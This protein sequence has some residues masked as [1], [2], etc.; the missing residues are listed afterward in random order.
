M[1]RSS[2]PAM[3]RR[4]RCAWRRRSVARW[5]GSRSTRATGSKTAEEIARIETVDLELALAAARAERDLAAAELRLQVGRLPPRGDRRGP[6]PGGARSGRSSRPPSAIWQRFQGLLD[7][8]SGIEK[9]RDDALARRDLAARTLDAI[10]ERL[11]KL[12]AG[13]RCRGDRRGPRPVWRRPRRASPRSSSRSRDA[14]VARSDLRHGDREAGRAGRDAA[15]RHAA[16][17]DHRPRRRLARRPRSARP[18]SAASASGRTPRWSPT[19]AS[20]A[21]AG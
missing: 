9:N 18:T 12:E 3:S 17:G 1:D 8:G 14:V 2:P 11:R 13:F 6:S 19:T 15:G 10:R 21:P 20:A 7:C 4:R 16:G 5:N